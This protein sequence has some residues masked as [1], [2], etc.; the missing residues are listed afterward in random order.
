MSLAGDV[1][2]ENYIK[3]LLKFIQRHADQP[4]D[5]VLKALED[6]LRSDLKAAKDGWL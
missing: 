4:A 5:V 6:S 3:E 1:A 2:V